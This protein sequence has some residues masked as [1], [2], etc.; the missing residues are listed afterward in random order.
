MKY[1]DYQYEF[2]VYRILALSQT[3]PHHEEETF[4]NLVR[5]TYKLQVDRLEIIKN[6]EGFE[7]FKSKWLRSG[8][9]QLLDANG[10]C[11][12]F[13]HV[14]AELC[15]TAGMPVRMVQLYQN[16]VYGAHI[17][18]EAKVNGRWA[19]ADGIFKT[20]FLNPDSSLANMDDLKNNLAYFEN[21]FP[22]NY[23]YK[24]AYNEFR[25]T[26]WQKIPVV[27]PLF[28]V[29]L[30]AIKGK[31][32]VKTFSMRSYLL[33]LHKVWFFGLLWVYIPVFFITIFEF[34]IFIKYNLID[35]K[36]S[37]HE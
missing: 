29:F 26:N 23:P 28:K 13:S 19:A 16:G 7:P 32:W 27:M 10:S 20:Y 2:A 5:L 35:K 25:Y 4:K 9:M 11:G 18:I 3:V 17:I 24:S 6:M 15:K 21:Q 36:T 1:I 22:D 8:D 31:E 12:N 33:N 14:L 30:T 37:K 34:W